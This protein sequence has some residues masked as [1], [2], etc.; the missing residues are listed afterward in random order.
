MTTTAPE[1]TEAAD[2]QPAE[3]RLPTIVLMTL[4]TYRVGPDGKV[5]DEQ[6]LREITSAQNL[7]PLASPWAWPPCQCPRH[8]PGRHRTA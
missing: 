5:T 8:A 1:P 4:R 7:A 2:E 6:P 3:A